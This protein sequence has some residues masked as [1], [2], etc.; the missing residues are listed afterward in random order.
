[1]GT[2]ATGEGID[3]E[4]E[5]RDRAAEGRMVR[6][7]ERL[8]RFR[9]HVV[10]A[11]IE[12]L[13]PLATEAIGR[14]ASADT[15]LR[16]AERNADSI[17]L[18]SRAGAAQPEGFQA[19]LLLNERGRDMLYDGTL[20]LADPPDDCLVAQGETP[21]LLYI[22]ATYTP[23][24]LA[25]GIQMVVDHFSSPR[26]RAVDMVSWAAGVRGER[27]LK[28]FGFEQGVGWKGREI[29]HFFISRRAPAS[30]AATRPRFDSWDAETSPTG[31]TVVH[32]I[33][34]L[35]KVA[36]IRAA[37]YMGEQACPF[38]EEFDG[39]DFA[40]THLLAYI[41][42]EPAGCMRVRFF[43]GF[44]KLERLAVRREFRRSRTA[45]ELVRAAVD[46]C[47]AK[48]FRK[49]YGHARTDYLD[50]WRSFGFALDP[51]AVP[52]SFS[53]LEFV[54][55]EHDLDAA[56]DA[57]SLSDGPYRIIRPE[58]RWDRRGPLDAPASR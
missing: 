50:F 39:N 6:R 52:F 29:A 47:R 20:D 57:V 14:L 21:A 54:E 58:G 3:G 11:D 5:S 15:I 55:M 49:L 28:R 32:G 44:A 41:G 18:F 26:Y 4:R 40:A 37:V 19:W 25:A 30:L 13:L 31:I 42:N 8:V 48:G 16:V 45:F 35:M 12:H 56:N 1:M 36:A 53:G 23:G 43:G 10:R 33:D 24:I 38:A 34:E 17:W 46:L 22:W 7:A 51:E 27:S 2:G 9:N